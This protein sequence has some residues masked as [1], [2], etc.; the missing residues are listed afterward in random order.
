M[1]VQPLRYQRLHRPSEILSKGLEDLCTAFCTI[2]NM[3][4]YCEVIRCLLNK[5]VHVNSSWVYAAVHSHADEHLARTGL[6][7]SS[8]AL[9]KP[10]QI[11]GFIFWLRYFTGVFSR[12][13]TDNSGWRRAFNTRETP[14]TVFLAFLF[15][16][17]LGWSSANNQLV[18]FLL[19]N[20][21]YWP[22]MHKLLFGATRFFVCSGFADSKIIMGYR[23]HRGISWWQS[24]AGTS[25]IFFTGHNEE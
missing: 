17:T 3:L 4:R 5:A 14:H 16:S 18:P 8:A 11:P 21:S 7:Y 15:C 9:P 25:E 6:I 22:K 12:P 1:I 2:L 23:F 13:K 10:H 19:I 20:L 24:V